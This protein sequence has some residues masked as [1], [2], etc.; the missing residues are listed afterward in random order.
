MVTIIDK[1]ILIIED[2]QPLA[3]A[4]E[5]KFNNTGLK[6][7]SVFDGSQAIEALKTETYD[8]IL[9][10]LI[11]P[12]VD[13]FKVLEFL[14]ENQIPTPV[15]VLSNLSQAEDEKRAKE[16]GAIDFLVKSNI[17]IKDIIEK[18]LFFI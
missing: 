7:K 3:S 2:D 11:M 15:I 5:L 12:N 9:C 16:L 6:A 10:D 8:V 4:L 14:Q 18:T 17:S 13:G 1:K